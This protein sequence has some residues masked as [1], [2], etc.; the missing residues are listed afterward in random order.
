MARNTVTLMDEDGD[1]SDWIEIYNP[2]SFSVPLTGWS[3]TDD[4][5]NL[6]KWRFAADTISAGAYLIVFASD[7]DRSSGP[8]FHTNFKLISAGEYLALLRPDSTMASELL[9]YPELQDDIS[10]AYFDQG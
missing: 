10:Y 4:S 3:L 6:S 2:G 7:K 1:Y 8:H 5:S 9:I